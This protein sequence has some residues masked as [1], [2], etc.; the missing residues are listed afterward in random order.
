MR[1]RNGLDIVLG[2]LF[3]LTGFNSKALSLSNSDAFYFVRKSDKNFY[4]AGSHT[5]NNLAEVTFVSK[6]DL[7]AFDISLRSSKQYNYSFNRYRPDERYDRNGTD[8]EKDFENVMF[9][10]TT[11]TKSDNDK[12]NHLLDKDSLPWNVHGKLL[13]SKDGHSL[14]YSDGTPFIWIGETSWALHQNLSRED[15][16]LYLDDV[17]AQGFNLIQLMT[18]NTWALN[19]FENFYGD[20]PYVNNKAI[21]LNLPYWSHLSWVID[22]AAERGLYVLLV[23]GA[24]GRIDNH[25][26]VTWLPDQAYL[27]GNKLGEIFALKKNLIW[28]NGMDVDPDNISRVSPMGMAGWYA[29]AEG[30]TDGV[31]GVY[32]FD[33]HADWEATLMTYHPS[34]P[35]I[36][37]QW[38]QYAPWL[39]FYGDQ[40]G[41]KEKLGLIDKIRRDFFRKPPKPIIN[42]EPWYE[43]CPWKDPPVN[44]WDVRTQAYQSVFASAFGH[45]YGHWNIY[46]FDSKGENNERNWRDALNAPGRMQMKY[47]K[48]L[49]ETYDLPKY[50]PSFDF[51]ISQK[52]DTLRV[53]EHI[54]ALIAYD[55]TSALVYS[56][57]GSSFEVQ[58]NLLTG[59][60]LSIVWYDPRKGEFKNSEIIQKIQNQ[61]FIAPGKPG[62]GN[63]WILYIKSQN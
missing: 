14:I 61:T 54:A 58:T 20:S 36:S 35:Q 17:K 55:R 23:Y 45:T 21:Q 30:V 13:V 28:A 8:T 31:N 42:L 11:G 10:K 48:L 3:F 4:L 41:W 33:G 24:P 47:L 50:K 5:R 9:S 25:G 51:I 60:K 63:D 46:P 15:V 22:R 18:V 26:P 62:D 38:F 19:N 52:Q 2:L 1:S 7:F 39:D 12:E 56:P 40:L 6:K 29:M 49:M 34:G 27:Y 16:L 53:D 57:Q 32:N 44:D 43:N 59:E 37:S